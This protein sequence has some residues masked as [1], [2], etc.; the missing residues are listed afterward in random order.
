MEP[1][2]PFHFSRIY[3]FDQKTTYL[4]DFLKLFPVYYSYTMELLR[5]NAQRRRQVKISILLVVLA[6]LYKIPLGLPQHYAVRGRGWRQTRL[7]LE[8]HS[9]LMRD[10]FRMEKRTFFGIVT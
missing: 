6:L 1:R 9:S 4:N 7:V 10:I 5:Q 2:P 8:G 3:L